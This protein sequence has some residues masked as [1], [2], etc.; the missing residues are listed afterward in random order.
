MHSDAIVLRCSAKEEAVKRQRRSM[1]AMAI[2]RQLSFDIQSSRQA[3]PRSFRFQRRMIALPRRWYSLHTCDCV[4]QR[5]TK[6]RWLDLCAE[7]VVVE[8]PGRWP[9]PESGRCSTEMRMFCRLTAAVSRISASP[10]V[11]VPIG[12]RSSIPKVFCIELADRECHAMQAAWW[13]FARGRAVLRKSCVAKVS[14]L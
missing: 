12:I 13:H 4:M 6:Q 2:F 1:S 10:S 5:E 7:A 8:D 9:S 11:I 3:L 14:P